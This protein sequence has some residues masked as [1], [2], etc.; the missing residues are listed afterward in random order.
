MY[1]EPTD[2]QE[3]RIG[4]KLVW[5]QIG[6]TAQFKKDGTLFSLIATSPK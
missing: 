5:A 6:L 2:A 3:S 4:V 1:G